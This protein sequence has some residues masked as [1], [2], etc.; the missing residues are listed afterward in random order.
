MPVATRK[1]RKLFMPSLVRKVIRGLAGGCR[2]RAPGHRGRRGC[3]GGRSIRIRGVGRL[4]QLARVQRALAA[5]VLL[6]PDAVAGHRHQGRAIR[7]RFAEPHRVSFFPATETATRTDGR[8]RIATGVQF[9][10]RRATTA[11][12]RQ[13]AP[14]SGRHG[15]PGTGPRGNASGLRRRQGPVHGIGL[16]ADPRRGSQE[17]ADHAAQQGAAESTAASHGRWRM[18][19]TRRTLAS[20]RCS[21]RS[22]S[23]NKRLRSA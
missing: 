5:T 16:A 8:V 13:F 22:R 19:S 21:L 2:R 17:Q 6:E 14:S 10:G 3:G 23:G 7:Q 20:C 1:G 11:G 18:A 4:V 9:R 15:Q 12:R